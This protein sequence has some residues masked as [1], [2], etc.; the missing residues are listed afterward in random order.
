MQ[1]SATPLEY[2]APAIA[3]VPILS[4][5]RTDTL[6]DWLSH[7]LKARGVRVAGALRTKSPKGSASYCDAVLRVLPDGPEVR[8][9]Q[10]LGTGSTACR[11]DAAAIETV[12]GLAIAH[13]DQ[14]GGDIVV[15]NKFGISEAEGRGFRSL[16]GAAVSRGIPVMIGVSETHRDAFNAFCDGMAVEVPASEQPALAWCLAAVGMKNP[17]AV[18]SAA[19]A[20]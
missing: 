9:T 16:I 11:L 17:A 4:D 1:N 3:V 20:R 18:S 14:A 8:I 7:A 6:L 19:A 5:G 10:D 13:L 2:A 15:L 12:A